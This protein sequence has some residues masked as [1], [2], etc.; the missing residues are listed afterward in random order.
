VTGE[1]ERNGGPLSGAERQRRWRQR[2]AQLRRQAAEEAQRQAARAEREQLPLLPVVAADEAERPRPGRPAGSVAR[3]TA[4]WR[5]MMLSRYR[6]PLIVM[7]EA[8]SRPVEEL[9]KALG[10]TRKEAF[11]LQL[12]AAAEL[13]PFV[14]SKMPI[15]VTGDQAPPTPVVLA[16]TERQAAALGAAMVPPVPMPRTVVNQALAEGDEA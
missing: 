13:A 16:V 10:C 12:R 3:V 4:E 1:A 8:Y 5:Q 9:A 7:A 14:H 6:S 15:A 11:E 2:Q